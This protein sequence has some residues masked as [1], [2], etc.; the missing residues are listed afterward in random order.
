MG[1]GGPTGNR[2]IRVL[3]VD[4]QERTRRAL[5][6][7]L[8]AYPDIDV[9]GEAATA[10]AA[11]RTTEDLDPDI[12]LLDSVIAARIESVAARH[13]CRSRRPT[14]RVILITMAAEPTSDAA[15][16]AADGFALKGCTNDV[17]HRGVLRA[18]SR[19]ANETPA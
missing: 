7:R 14:P 10:E 5:R 6:K 2:P 13:V 18:C 4:D 16:T 19:S 1:A 11:I 9:V 12:V 15:M 8:E 17:Q 3:L